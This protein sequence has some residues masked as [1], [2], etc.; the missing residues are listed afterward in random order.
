MAGVETSTAPAEEVEAPVGG[1]K[2]F[3]RIQGKVYV[4]DGDEY[5]TDDDPKGD[6][7]IDRNGNLLG[8]ESYTS[9]ATVAL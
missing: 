1:G 8:G 9:C 3:H 4:I 7:K 2:P 5:V 6:T